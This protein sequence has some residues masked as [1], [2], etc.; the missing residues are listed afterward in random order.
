MNRQYL[1]RFAALCLSLLA[2]FSLFAS[3]PFADTVCAEVKIEIEQEISLERQGFDAHMRINNGGASIPLENVSITVS[4]ADAVGNT[5]Q[6]SA[7]PDRAAT[8]V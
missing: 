5:V 1:K 6:A 8:K 2:L 7:D 3:Q 4:F